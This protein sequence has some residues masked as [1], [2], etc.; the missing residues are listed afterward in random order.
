MLS[1]NIHR[2][3]MG[4]KIMKKNWIAIV[5][6]AGIL[7]GAMP[8]HASDETVTVYRLYNRNTGEHLYTVNS[9]EKD[10]LKAAGWADEGIGWYGCT[11]GDPV[12]RLY[13]PNVRGGDHY[14][15]V[16]K[17]EADGLTARGWRM[18]N[19]GKPAF[20]SAGDVNLYVAYNPNASSGAHNYTTSD[21][22]QSSLLS[23]GWKYGAVAWKV[24]APGKTNQTINTNTSGATAGQRAALAKAKDYLD[25]MAYSY[26]GLIDQLSSPYGEGMSLSDAT[27]AAD[28][29]GADWNEQAVR[30]AKSYL[31]YGSFSYQGLIDQLASEYGGKFTAEQAKYGADHSGGDW[32]SEAVEAARSYLEIGSFTRESLMEQLTS[33]YGSKFTEAQAAYACSQVGL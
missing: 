33:E 32:N 3:I 30:S 24:A 22:E 19:G 25:F 13:N 8:V 17:A 12:Y 27:Y 26:Q 21:S 9:A 10:N 6:S 5:F 18:D 1:Y 29:C 7:L 11:S 28:H 20:Y 15:T 2:Y 16:N 23:S 14:Y 31:K 4:R